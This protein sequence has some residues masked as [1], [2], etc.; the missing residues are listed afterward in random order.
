MQTSLQLGLSQQ[1]KISP[2]LQQAI[3]LLQMSS[4]EL[5]QEI[6]K[7][8][9]SNLLLEA[10]EINTDEENEPLFSQFSG[11]TWGGDY[12]DRKKELL[13]QKSIETTLREH[14]YWQMEISHFSER[15]KIIAIAL[16]D[17]ISEEG[18]LLCP[19]SDIQESLQFNMQTNEP[20]IEAVLCRIQQFEP[21]GVGARNLSECLNIQL[22]HLPIATPWMTKLKLLVSEHLEILGKRDYACLKN[23]LNLNSV[24]LKDLI[25]ILTSLNPK[26]GIQL[27]SKKPEY[28]IPDVIVH[29]KNNQCLV[30]LNHTFIP[31][32]RV[33]THYADMIQQ[34]KI[35]GNN[36]VLLKKYLEEAKYF[37]KGLQTRHETLL[38]VA[39]CILNEQ[40]DFLTFGEEKMKPLSLQDIAHKTE[41]HESTISRITTQKYILT[42]R[43]IF[44]LKYFF[45]NAITSA[46]G[47]TASS[48][49]IRAL[50]K[51][52]IAKETSQ[53]PFSDHKIT[54]LLLECGI[55]I[56]RRTVTKYREAMRL[57][58]SN[59]RKNLGFR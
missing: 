16:I 55:S 19:L 44:E 59:E 52:I 38:K 43:G 4:L 13:L 18:Y 9:E 2:R 58:A 35:R 47:K 17:A 26:P 8:L 7:C 14:L 1:L 25:K 6:E 21:L 11:E 30:E 46:K 42:K 50:I 5:K 54:Q 23:K 12:L 3:K 34:K 22:N 53:A 37:L 40:K 36:T 45:S 27:S 39:T 51:K 56:A 28:I 32:L 33:N 41:L 31:K 49:A 29:Q 20:E 24:E 10:T 48:T 57:P 15:D